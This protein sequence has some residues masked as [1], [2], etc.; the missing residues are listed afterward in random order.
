[1]RGHRDLVLACGL[2]LVCAVAALLLPL[3]ALRVVFALPLCLVLPG[4]AITAATFARLPL[5]KAQTALLSVALSLCALAL[6]ALAL[7]YLGGLRSGTWALLL[8]AIVLAGCRAAAVRRPNRGTRPQP[9]LPRVPLPQVVLYCA[10]TAAIAAAVGLAFVVLPAK[11]AI[12]HTDLWITTAEEGASSVVQVG[13]RSQ[14]Q[15]ATSYFVRIR[16]GS[17]EKPAIKLFDLVPGEERTIRLEV[18][19]AAQPIP[20]TAALFRQS[21][22]EQVYRQVYT[23]VGGGE[24]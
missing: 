23:A 5:G 24:A 16:V 9:A 6:G 12:G 10:G 21:S 22:P 19:A 18:P 8:V 1:M 14:E 11:N 15:H 13:V 3:T 20:A 4:Y 17:A 7:N 2:A